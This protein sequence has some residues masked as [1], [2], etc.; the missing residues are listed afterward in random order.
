LGSPW[1]LKKNP[2]KMYENV[3]SQIATSGLK[4]AI[5]AACPHTQALKFVSSEE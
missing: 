2:T 4:I 1:S 5:S 3:N